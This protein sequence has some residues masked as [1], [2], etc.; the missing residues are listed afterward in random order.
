MSQEPGHPKYLKDFQQK[1]K[2][3]V[4]T[5]KIVLE[6][7]LVALVLLLGMVAVALVVVG[8]PGLAPYL[9]WLK[10]G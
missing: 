9:D 8:G 2:E 3:P 6:S 10:V 7:L 1:P 4:I 5:I